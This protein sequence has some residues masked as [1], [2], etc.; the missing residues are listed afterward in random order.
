MFGALIDKSCL[1]WE[2]DCEGGRKCWMY[3]NADM[4]LYFMSLCLGFKAVS[5]AC[6]LGAL[7]TFREAKEDD[8]VGEEAQETVV[9][10][11]MEKS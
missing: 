10:E 9:T 2:E 1:I 11:K 3:D 8:E 6:G 5:L 7:L 4:A